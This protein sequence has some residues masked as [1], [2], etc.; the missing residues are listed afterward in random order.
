[1]HIFGRTGRELRDFPLHSLNV[2]ISRRERFTKARVFELQRLANSRVFK[3]KHAYLAP[4]LRFQFVQ[5]LHLHTRR[6]MIMNVLFIV[7]ARGIQSCALYTF[8]EA[9]HQYQ[10]IEETL[11]DS[12]IKRQH[13]G[14][15]GVY[16]YLFIRGPSNLE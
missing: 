8:G 15:I 6:E 7:V 9:G 16:R 1:M 3:L 5:G 12:D 10:E 4:V 11:S 2:A 14:E 13:E